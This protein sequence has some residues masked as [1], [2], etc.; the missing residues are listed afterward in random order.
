MDTE[1]FTNSNDTNN[2][3]K[4]NEKKKRTKNIKRNG[5]ETLKET[6]PNIKRNGLKH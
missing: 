3:A 1:E 2:E 4:V 5:P 6:D